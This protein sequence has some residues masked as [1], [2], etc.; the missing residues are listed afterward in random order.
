MLEKKFDN[1]ILYIVR[2]LSNYSGSLLNEVKGLSYDVA[3]LLNEV[4]SLPHEV[5]VLSKYSYIEIW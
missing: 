4:R 3:G 2:G 1:I 5:R